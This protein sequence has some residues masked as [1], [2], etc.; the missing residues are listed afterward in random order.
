MPSP[1]DWISLAQAAENDPGVYAAGLSDLFAKMSSGGGLFGAER[2]QWFNGGLFDSAD[3]LS[4]AAAEILL[5]DTVSRLDWSQVE[6]AIFGTLFER[7]LDPSKRSQLGAHYTDRASILRLIEPVVL[8][9]LRRDF[10]ETKARIVALLAEGKRVTA[11]TRAEKNPEGLL[12]AFLERLRAV[13]VLDPACGSGNF[14]YLAL[15]ALKD[16]EREAI[17]WGSLTLQ[18]TMQLPR[19]GPE[20]V[21]GLELNAYASELARVCLLY[22][23]DAA[24]E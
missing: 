10:A 14:L 11:R 1:A 18:S 24:D 15:Q 13:R 23:S 7:G 22:T 19:V 2:I 3:V 4:L 9:P 16:L 6:P 20:V 17:L 21:L 5:V 12:N 8:E